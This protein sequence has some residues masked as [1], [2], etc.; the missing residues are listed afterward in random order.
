MADSISAAWDAP[1]WAGLVSGRESHQGSNAMQGSHGANH[2]STIIHRDDTSSVLKQGEQGEV[3]RQLQRRLLGIGYCD[4]DG[5]PRADGMFGD[6]TRQAVEAFQYDYGL[7]VDG[8]VGPKTVLA[9]KH[10]EYAHRFFKSSAT[11]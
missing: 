8:V 11:R 3:V 5:A 9:L 4:V 10:A 6:R 2:D 7:I 1:L